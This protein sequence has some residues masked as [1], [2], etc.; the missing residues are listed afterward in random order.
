MH[1]FVY[2]DETAGD[3]NADVSRTESNL[4]NS[5]GD[6]NMSADNQNGPGS[7]GLLNSVKQEGDH[8]PTDDLPPGL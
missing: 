8:N 2:S 3:D 1:L 6:A 5:L 4:E 7:Q